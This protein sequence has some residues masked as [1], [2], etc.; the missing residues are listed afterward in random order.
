MVIYE[1]SSAPSGQADA[2]LLRSRP[3]PRLSRRKGDTCFRESRQIPDKGFRADDPLSIWVFPPSAT[4]SG[5]GNGAD[6]IPQT[7]PGIRLG[8]EPAAGNRALCGQ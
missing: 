3:S 4:P 5:E 2:Q 1:A 6:H 7:G 8:I